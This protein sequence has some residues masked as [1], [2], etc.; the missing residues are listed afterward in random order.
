MVSFD[1]TAYKA[2]LNIWGKDKVLVKELKS[3]AEKLRRDSTSTAYASV[4]LAKLYAVNPSWN[5]SE[6]ATHRSELAKILRPIKKPIVKQ[7]LE[8]VLDALGESRFENPAFWSGLDTLRQQELTQ[9]RENFVKYLLADPSMAYKAVSRQKLHESFTSQGVP[10]SDF[11]SYEESLRDNGVTIFDEKFAEDVA[12]FSI[13]N[14]VAS[15]WKDARNKGT[16]STIF[17]VLLLHLPKKERQQLSFYSKLAYGNADIT[18]ATINRADQRATTASDSNEVQIAHK[19]LASFKNEVKD[20]EELKFIVFK[21]FEEFVDK[22][23]QRGELGAAVAGEL[24]DLG[25]TQTDANILVSLLASTGGSQPVN[26]LTRTEAHLQN[27]E[28]GSAQQVFGTSDYSTVD[29][30]EYARVEKLLQT[31]KSKKKQLL[32]NYK[33]ALAGNKLEE[34]RQAI[35]EAQR[36]DTEDESLHGKLDAIPPAPAGRLTAS[37]ATNKVTLSWGKSV[38]TDVQYTVVRKT[39]SASSSPVDGEIIVQNTPALTAEDKKPLIAQVVFYTVFAQRA[40]QFSEAVSTKTEVYPRPDNLTAKA[41]SSTSIYVSWTP[42]SEASSIAVAVFDSRGNIIREIT[43]S[44]SSML[45]EHLTTGEKYTISLVAKYITPAG[46]VT[47]SNV[48]VSAVPRENATPIKGIDHKSKES[49]IQLDWPSASS[50]FAV[51]AWVLP[52]NDN[53]MEFGDV[54]TADHLASL[55]GYRAALV[56]QKEVDGRTIYTI[57]AHQ[58]ILRVYPLVLVE[59]GYLV[60]DYTSSG[61]I[62]PAKNITVEYFNDTIKLAWE[63]TGDTRQMELAWLD[64]HKQP[65]REIV[66]LASYR[67]NGGA[68]IRGRNISNL[69]IAAVTKVDGETIISAPTAISLKQENKIEISYE[70]KIKGGG[71]FSKPSTTITARNTNGYKGTVPVSLCLSLKPYVPLSPDGCMVLERFTLDFS[72]SDVATHTF[73]I[74]KTAIPKGTPQFWLVMFPQDTTETKINQPPT[75]QL[76]G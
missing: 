57:K 3:V 76:K 35:I 36:I 47:S 42:L 32:E 59:S 28:L 44:A 67:R 14:G 54:V 34:A 31:Q 43:T 61:V 16:F 5:A 66:S 62:E 26:G 29:Q 2:Q 33:S 48:R 4:D 52:L 1:S 55:G 60:G 56:S 6:L 68:I 51:E 37:T 63:W 19:I 70:Q 11:Q 49:E 50:G 53:G 9:K 39:G 22:K 75:N 17:D 10:S 24:V 45:L 58:G 46:T 38:S 73:E 41:N 23:L 7:G 27:G 71:F 69:T 12:S 30:D 8:P 74:P 72:A 65:H 13:P 18:I 64:T 40:G 21:I 15:S 20:N 25:V